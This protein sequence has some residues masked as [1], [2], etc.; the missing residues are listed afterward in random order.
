MKRPP[1]GDDARLWAEV[2]ATVRP[3]RHT[4]PAP[5]R[6]AARPAVPGAPASPQPPARP[7]GPA[8]RARPPA[9]PPRPDPRPIEPGR[10][11]R[12][13]KAHGP[14]L[15][16]HGMTWDEA[17][18]AVGAFLQRVHAGG[19]REALVI[20]GKGALGDGVLRRCLPDWLGE[21]PLSALVAGISPAH[22]RHGGEGALY[23]ALR[24]R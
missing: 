9:P 13:G 4:P 19:G 14:V 2:C 17:R 3:L 1:A 8:P 15:D 22:R 12:I 23:V 7:K 18:A 10:L 11:R 21:P 24:R 5:A 20:T 16:L 6:A